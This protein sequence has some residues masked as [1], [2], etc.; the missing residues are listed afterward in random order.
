MRPGLGEDRDLLD[1]VDPEI[2]FEVQIELEHVVGIARPS[3]HR[4]DDE[5]DDL[6]ESIRARVRTGARASASLGCASLG[7][8]SLGCASFRSASR[9]QGSI[10]RGSTFGANRSFGA[11]AP[12]ARRLRTARASACEQSGAQILGDLANGAEVAQLERGI[13]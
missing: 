6:G 3:D 7:C 1:R 9:G 13:L 12:R 5:L 4:L 8:A 10:E 11:R 2:G